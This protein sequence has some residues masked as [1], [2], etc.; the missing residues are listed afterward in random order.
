MTAATL[1]QP[2]GQ[3][4]RF[5]CVG[6]TNTLVSFLAYSALLAAAT[7]YAVAAVLAFAAGAVNGYVLNRRWT[8][9]AADS[10]RARLVYVC[11]QA[12]G[13]LTAGALVWLLVHTTAA[14]HVAA[15]AAAI[16]PVTVA[17]FLAN[18]RW[19]FADQN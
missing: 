16:P 9:A 3:F 11:V 13:A 1:R 2:L 4:V 7:P 5:T 18:R 17:T 15:Y 12:A 19:A 8:F 14:G 6:A 10:R